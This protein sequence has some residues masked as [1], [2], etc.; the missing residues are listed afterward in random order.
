MHHVYR[1]LVAHRIKGYERW[2]TTQVMEQEPLDKQVKRLIDTFDAGGFLERVLKPG[3]YMSFKWFQDGDNLITPHSLDKDNLEAMTAREILALAA[4]CGFHSIYWMDYQG[5]LTVNYI[6]RNSIYLHKTGEGRYAIY[7]QIGSW[8]P[9]PDFV[10]E[11]TM[12]QEKEFIN[13][14]EKYHLEVQ[15]N[16][17]S[18]NFIRNLYGMGL[19]SLEDIAEFTEPGFTRPVVV[20]KDIDCGAD[21]EED[22]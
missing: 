15:Y 17:A 6:N 12:S 11:L 20:P 2:F 4:L 16:H 14:I 18:D 1:A 21:E 10:C 9:V 3:R 5:D 8:D 22:E 19:L 13:E 7:K